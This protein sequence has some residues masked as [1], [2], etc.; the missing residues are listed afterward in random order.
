MLDCYVTTNLLF[1]NECWTV[2]ADMRSNAR[3]KLEAAEMWFYQRILKIPW[4]GH[5]TNEEVLKKM[6]TERKLL[7]AVRKR[8]LEF[9]GN[10]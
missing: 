9:F 7:L 2:S 1:A 4:A 8:Q 3:S 5:V 10:V 6:G